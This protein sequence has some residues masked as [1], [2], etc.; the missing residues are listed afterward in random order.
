MVPGVWFVH[1]DYCFIAFE[2][3]ASRGLQTQLIRWRLDR[4]IRRSFFLSH[5]VSRSATLLPIDSC[6]FYVRI[7][8]WST[9]PNWHV[10]PKDI[11]SELFK[12]NIN[13]M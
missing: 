7:Q 5:T 12:Y 9:P 13:Y 10:L 4:H 3:P 1:P 2:Y 11:A 6:F 8:R